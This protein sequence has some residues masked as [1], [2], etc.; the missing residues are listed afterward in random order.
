HRC[1]APGIAL[2]CRRRAARGAAMALLELS[3]SNLPTADHAR[4]EPAPGSNVLTGEPGAGKTIIVDAPAR[5]LAAEAAAA[6]VRGGPARAGSAPRPLRR[7]H[8]AAR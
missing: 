8:G 3:T 1:H 5:P 7:A 2:R 6:D 4:L